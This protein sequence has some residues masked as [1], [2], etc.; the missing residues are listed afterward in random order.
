MLVFRNSKQPIEEAG[1]LLRCYLEEGGTQVPK[2]FLSS[3]GS[4]LSLLEHVQ[5]GVLGPH[6]TVSVLDER[7]SEDPDIN[8]FA[9]LAAH[10]FYVD[11]QKHGSLF[12]DTRPQKGETCDM[13]RERFESALRL[14]RK[15]NPNGL[16][17]VTQGIAENGHTAGIMPMPEDPEKFSKLFE[18]DA[19]VANYHVDTHVNPCT[20]RIT[21]T[22]SFLRN[23]VDT[24]VG[25]A[26]DEKKREILGRVLDEKRM[27]DEVPARI[28]NQMKNVI[29][30]SNVL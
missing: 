12:I 14:W 20:E 7:F 26:V 8:N 22:L 11:A 13:L 15:E 5:G 3:G 16:I 2:L 30:V 19:W 4:S 9:Q 21:T 27:L 29:I 23:E 28:M 1:A 6:I 24:S 18:G 17:I 10:P 25:F